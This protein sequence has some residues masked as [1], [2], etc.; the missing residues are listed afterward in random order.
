M[1]QAQ[2]KHEIQCLK[3]LCE[4]EQ[5][6]M[7]FKCVEECSDSTK[8]KLYCNV[9]NTLCANGCLGSKHFFFFFTHSTVPISSV[10][11]YVFKKN[12]ME[13]IN[14]FSSVVNDLQTNI[15]INITFEY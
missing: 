13:V 5:T 7:T 2:K 6:F 10:S 11:S 15:F 8:Q 1:K 4:S 9:D 3:G 14:S 12:R